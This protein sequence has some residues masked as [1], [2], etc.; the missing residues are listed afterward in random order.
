[1]KQRQFIAWFV[2]SLSTTDSAPIYLRSINF[3]GVLKVLSKDIMPC[4]SV[5][6][7]RLPGLQGNTDSCRM[8]FGYDVFVPNFGLPGLRGAP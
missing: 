4:L 5:R 2:R 6:K 1:M 7:Y 3:D 8:T